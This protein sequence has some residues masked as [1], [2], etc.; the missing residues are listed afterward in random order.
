[1]RCQYF[2]GE[3]QDDMK[4]V[5]Y[6]TK[7]G[8][9]WDGLI[10][11]AQRHKIQVDVLGWGTQWKGFG[12]RLLAMREY[13]RMLPDH[14]IVVFVDAYDV[15][16]LRNLSSMAAEYEERCRLRGDRIV[17]STEARGAGGTIFN[18]YFGQCANENIN[19]GT[20]IGYAYLIR[21][22]L[23]QV[24][25]DAGR[26]ADRTADDQYMLTRFCDHNRDI[27][28][29]DTESDWF[30]VWGMND[31]IGN[32]VVLKDGNFFYKGKR[33]YILHCPANRDMSKTL[34]SLGYKVPPTHIR[35]PLEYFLKT[36]PYSV[37]SFLKR[38]P[39]ALTTLGVIIIIVILS[40]HNIRR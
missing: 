37:Q 4:V 32:D 28:G 2:L 13:V 11:S 35:S 27:F 23:N 16:F 22:I 24:C 7:P 3:V 14:E 5:L 1:M 40:R 26:C 34:T 8:G 36:G 10:A 38:H 31:A 17:L 18:L 15:V 39:R 19:A 12:H 25:A 6:A 29:F 9:Y 33:P 30:L 21:N 20:Y